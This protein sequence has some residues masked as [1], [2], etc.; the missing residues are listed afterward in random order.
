MNNVNTIFTFYLGRQFV[1]RFLAFLAFFVIILQMLDLLNESDAILAADGAGVSSVFDYIAMRSPQIVS[2]FAPFAALLAIVITL[3]MLNHTSEITI[4]RAAGMSVHR[5]LFPIGF[6]CFLVSV[7]H[8]TFHET[9]VVPSTEKLAYWQANDYAV[10][11]PPDKGT[12]TD[13][14]LS[15]NGEF[16][17]AESAARIGDT[18]RLNDVVIDRLDANGLISGVVEAKSALFINN[19]WQLFGVIDHDGK[20]LQT[21]RV[22]NREWATNLNPELLFALSLKPDRTPMGDLVKKIGQLR[23]D[24][25]D[26][27]AA[28]TSFLARFSKPLS[29]LVMPLLG[30]IAGFGVARQGAQLTRAAIGASLG[31]GYFVFENMALALGKLGVLPAMVGAFFPFA[32]FMV[33][34]FAIL[35]TM[36]T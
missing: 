4:M 16:I 33:V 27:R 23:A 14:R 8:F 19:G 15:Y 28:A 10:D 5:V 24:G 3:A 13:V 30:A 26:T 20:T 25:A 11:L 12:R 32:L 2:Q 35:L 34:G 6:V 7:A 1:A 9:I 31:F 29:T 18:V 22:D 36:E 17:R 21:T